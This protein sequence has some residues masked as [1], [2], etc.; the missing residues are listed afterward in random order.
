MRKNL[1]RLL[2]LV[3]LLSC[4]APAAL[5]EKVYTNST[6]DCFDFYPAKITFED[7]QV[8]VEGYFFNFNLDRTIYELSELEISVYDTS[9][10]LICDGA[11]SELSDSLRNMKL[12]PGLSSLQTFTFIETMRNPDNFDLSA[13]FSTGISCNF[14][15]TAY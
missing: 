4:F 13:G 7:N 15:S 9:G 5:A 6:A 1:A 10:K 11:F 8:I 3:L 12:I 14:T 2:A